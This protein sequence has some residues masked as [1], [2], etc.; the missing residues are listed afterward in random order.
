[1][2]LL[3]L[4]AR[5]PRQ[6]GRHVRI[7]RV[8]HHPSPAQTRDLLISA[9]DGADPYQLAHDL[10]HPVRRRINGFGKFLAAG[11]NVTAIG[12]KVHEELRPATTAV[13]PLWDGGNAH[14]AIPPQPFE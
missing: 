9:G 2:H 7:H 14:T 1:M 4:N 5:R 8:P 6:F 11:V 13:A 10:A 12:F 3:H